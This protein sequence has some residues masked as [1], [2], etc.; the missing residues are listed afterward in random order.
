[1]EVQELKIILHQLMVVILFLV[2]LRRMAV[3]LVE[4]LHLLQMMVD[5]VVGQVEMQMKLLR[6]KEQ[7][8]KVL[9]VEMDILGLQ[10][11]KLE[12]AAVVLEL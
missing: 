10:M 1:M 4:E 9:M 6:A 3:V 12:E 5:L 8:V 2:L 7:L 11:M